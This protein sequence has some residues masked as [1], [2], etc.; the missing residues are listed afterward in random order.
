MNGIFPSGKQITVKIQA[1]SFYNQS[2]Q[3]WMDYT[4]SFTTQT[5]EP[6]SV[7][8]KQEGKSKKKVKKSDWG[9]KKKLI[10]F[11]PENNIIKTRRVIE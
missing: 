1:K 5:L 10:L 9:K 7:L 6:I 8:I 2:Q 4:Y 11:L 3:M